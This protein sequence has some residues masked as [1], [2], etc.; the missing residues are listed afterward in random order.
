LNEDR[1]FRFTVD[2]PQGV[3][4]VLAEVPTTYEGQVF[5]PF[6]EIS[7]GLL[8]VV[9]N[10]VVRKDMILQCSVGVRVGTLKRIFKQFSIR[11]E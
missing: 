11:K 5:V 10:R 8:L 1:L 6:V 4:F 2:F 3:G 7:R 9:R